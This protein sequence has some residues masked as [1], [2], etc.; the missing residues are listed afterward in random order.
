MEQFDPL[1]DTDALPTTR[2]FLDLG[3][4]HR[5]RVDRW[6]DS[7][8]ARLWQQANGTQREEIDALILQELKRVHADSIASQRRFVERFGFH[9]ASDE[10]RL[11]LARQLLTLRQTLEAEL[12][13]APL[14]DASRPSVLAAAQLLQLEI[15]AAAQRWPEAAAW[16]ARYFPQGTPQ[17]P[18]VMAQLEKQAVF[19]QERALHGLILP[20]GK[21]H[22]AEQRHEVENRL[23]S[24]QTDLYRCRVLQA[25]PHQEPRAMVLFNSGRSSVVV[26][27]VLGRE[28]QTITLRRERAASLNNMLNVRFLGHLML[29]STGNEVVAM[30]TLQ[31]E[32]DADQSILWRMQTHA[33]ADDHGESFRIGIRATAM[34]NAVG[35][36]RFALRDVRGRLLGSTSPLAPNGVCFL[37]HGQL[38]CVSPLTGEVLWQRSDIPGSVELTSDEE[39]LYVLPTEGSEAIVLRRDDGQSVKLVPVP[40]YQQ[41]LALAHGHVLMEEQSGQTPGTQLVTLKLQRLSDGAVL[42]QE[43]LAA[44]TQSCFVEDDEIVMLQPSGR[45][46]IR[47]LH[48]S[49]VSLDVTLEREP[50]LEQLH[51]L[52]SREQYLI[53]AGVRVVERLASWRMSTAPRATSE[54]RESYPY[55]VPFTGKIYAFHRAT[56]AAQWSAPAA[57]SE[58]GLPLDQPLEQPVLVLHRNLE[59]RSG[60]DGTESAAS[61]LCLDKR[62][63]ELLYFADEIPGTIFEYDVE[64]A[65]DR[66]SVKVLIPQRTVTL[67]FTSDPSPP[68]PP[69]QFDQAFN[70]RKGITG[71]LKRAL[72][73][74][75][76]P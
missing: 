60:R 37:S 40:P 76:A 27:D 53:F 32:H 62:T 45:C 21:V 74:L 12:L 54:E 16:S 34:Q 17:A 9:A 41:R 65:A 3:G 6:I 47:S 61:L 1:A 38:Q 67:K 8:A 69:V 19:A 25:D 15:L 46:V 43:Q 4:T 28:L 42:W 35:L 7:T 22:V 64:V 5:L 70:V 14:L 72:F 44:G 73:P 29:V 20:T 75:F 18:S 26:R 2:A 30:N 52:R 59:S 49:A 39:F 50:T 71:G 31:F 56:G 24:L 58:M 55:A 11:Q 51:V 66:E 33:L 36:S 48:D 68:T 63:G 23:E 13:L 10:V 57:I